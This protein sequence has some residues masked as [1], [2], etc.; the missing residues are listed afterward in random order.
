MLWA[1]DRHFDQWWLLCLSRFRASAFMSNSNCLEFMV[2]D[3]FASASTNPLTPWGISTTPWLVLRRYHRLSMLWL[4]HINCYTVQAGGEM[5]SICHAMVD[6]NSQWEKKRAI[7]AC[8]RRLPV[9]VRSIHML[10]VVKWFNG[11]K[12]TKACQVV[13]WSKVLCTQYFTC[14]LISQTRVG[15]IRLMVA[16]LLTIQLM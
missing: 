5:E 12:C 9:I 2:L 14:Q 7:N 3:P 6:R 10:L 4:H 16:E 13:S 15:V 11:R 1:S 8:Y